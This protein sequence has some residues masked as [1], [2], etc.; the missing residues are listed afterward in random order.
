MIVLLSLELTC[1]YG[2]VAAVHRN[3]L[4]IDF[5]KPGWRACKS[6]RL[7]AAFLDHTSRRVKALANFLQAIGPV[8]RQN[9]QLLWQD[10]ST[11]NL[12]IVIES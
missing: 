4:R 3:I 7:L 10:V 5:G 2:K 8:N 12:T 9:G 11:F 6:T 1:S